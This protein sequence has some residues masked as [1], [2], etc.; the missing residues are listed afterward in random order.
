M[1]IAYEIN[2]SLYIFPWYD[3]SIV[4]KKYDYP[5]IDSDWPSSTLEVSEDFV[6]FVVHLTS[7]LIRKIVLKRGQS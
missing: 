3:V 4:L 7:R 6:G 2:D 1:H 5:D